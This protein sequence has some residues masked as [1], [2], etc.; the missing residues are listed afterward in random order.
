MN[1]EAGQLAIDVRD[2]TAGYDG[3]AVLR[4]ISFS[5]PAGEILVILGGSGCGKSTLL[6]HLIGLVPPVSGDILIHGESIVTA[7]GSQRE[8]ILKNIGVLFQSGA[9]FGSQNL[10]ENI[11]LPLAEHADL[12]EPVRRILIEFKLRMVGLVHRTWYLPAEISGGEKK[13]AG[14]ARALALEP[15][16][17]FFDEPSAG[18]DPLSSAALDRLIVTLNESLGLT[19][20]VVTHELRSIFTIAHR[21]IM[22]DRETK[23]II[24]DGDPLHLRDHSPDKKVRDF[25]SGGVG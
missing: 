6:K 20:V 7:E 24:A 11:E 23:S 10:F 3:N 18:L 4:N 9:L 15:R 5:V 1:S 13:R 8:R 14:L 17:L 2:L 21:A 22:L 25:L 19:I 12:P 16:I